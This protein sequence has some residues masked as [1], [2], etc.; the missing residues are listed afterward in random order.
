MHFLFWW[1]FLWVV[2]AAGIVSYCI[3]ASWEV[4]LDTSLKLWDLI[5]LSVK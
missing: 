5:A 2:Q 3:R 1:F 4:A